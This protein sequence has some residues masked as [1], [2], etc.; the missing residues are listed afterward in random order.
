MKK[1]LCAWKPVSVTP[2][3]LVHK[4]KQNKDFS[5]KKIGF[6]GR[7]DPMAEGI[8]LFLV[9]DENK[10]RKEYERLPKTYE[11][12]VLFGVSTDTYD[13]MGL[14]TLYKK[15]NPEKD[16]D[17]P[18]GSLIQH[19]PPFSYIK[20]KG[21][22]LYFW[23]RE[24]KLDEI[25]IPSKTVKIYDY[26]LLGKYNMPFTDL[27]NNLRERINATVGDFRQDEIIKAW[28]NLY[29]ANRDLEFR[30]YKFEVNCSSGTYIRSIAN[31][32]GRLHGTGAIA[33]WITRTRVGNYSNMNCE[34]EI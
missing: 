10:K 17:L 19:Y 32:L 16:V 4:L 27:F 29:E 26:K 23:A 8:M 1:V 6:A 2:F 34:T 11:F 20:V 15:Q 31:D 21:K 30:V 9:G 33:Y 3:Q 5:D 24:N 7:L 14:P 22:P 25:T 28:E 18:I 12:E 13:V